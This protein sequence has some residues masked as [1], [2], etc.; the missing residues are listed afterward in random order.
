MTRDKIVKA[1]YAKL[2]EVNKPVYGDKKGDWRNLGKN[3][4]ADVFFDL[5]GQTPEPEAPPPS[6]DHGD[7]IKVLAK[8]VEWF[9]AYWSYDHFKGVLTT[10]AE[11]LDK[12]INEAMDVVARIDS[13][14]NGTD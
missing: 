7:D 14:L 2:E 10:D 13:V 3:E 11:D 5:A 4:I 8:A 1:L 12:A 6:V 9:S